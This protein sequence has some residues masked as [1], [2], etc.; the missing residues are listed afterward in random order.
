MYT[1]Y[2]SD[3]IS[4]FLYKKTNRELQLQRAL[5]NL[6]VTYKLLKLW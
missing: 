3:Q 5:L 1:A 4:C 2:K 6:H